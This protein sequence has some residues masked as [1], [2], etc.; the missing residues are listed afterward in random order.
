MQ[1]LACL[2]GQVLPLSEAQV[3]ELARQLLDA[4]AYCHSK[5]VFHRDIKP[6]NVI[7][8]PEGRATLVDFGLVK[9]CDPHDDRTRTAIRGM[10]TPEYAPPEQYG[11]HEHT[12]EK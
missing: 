6:Q 5:G 1:E 11:G 2:N 10:G 12:D 4:L 9:L 7:V 3:L 8:S